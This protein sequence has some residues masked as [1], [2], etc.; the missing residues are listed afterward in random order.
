LIKEAL[1]VRRG[2]VVAV[3]GAGGKTTLCY[4][5][6]SEVRAAGL[7]VMV[8]TTTHM[9]VLPLETTGPLFV[10][11]EGNPREALLRALAR[12]G[13]ATLL[14]RRVRDDKLSG[15]SPERVD[16]LATLADVVVIEAD[17]AR[18]RSLKTP[19]PHEP[20]IPN[21]ATLLAVLA[22]LDV[23]GQPLSHERVHRLERVLVATGRAAGDVCDEAAL[24]ATLCD[25]AGYPAR[26][27]HG[28]RVGVFLNKVEQASHWPPATRIAAGLLPPYHFVAAG[29][30]RSG[31]ARLLA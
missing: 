27:R 30:A 16:E 14:G 28:L 1:R 13:R 26:L 4:R 2:D 10:L 12:E 9:G 5:L 20:V 3:A 19:A 18:Q 22:G 25:P 7:T 21:S 11:A 17:G 15:L 31:D 29:S 6:A 24:V 8:T 23:L